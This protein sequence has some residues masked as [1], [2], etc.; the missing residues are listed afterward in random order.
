M[1]QF[2]WEKDGINR[3]QSYKYIT[4]KQ[5]K[6]NFKKALKA[7]RIWYLEDGT[8]LEYQYIPDVIR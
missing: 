1:G 5:Y 2:A 3:Y 7:R 8:T 4:E 6:A